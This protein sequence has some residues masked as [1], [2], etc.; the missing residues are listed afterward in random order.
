MQISTSVGE[1]FSALAKV[2]RT[3]K[4]A[5]LD[6]SN[7][8]FRSKYASL[9]SVLAAAR[10]ACASEGISIIQLAGTNEG[11]A[12]VTTVLGHSS[13]EWISSCLE[14]PLD[15]PT[16]QGMGSALT[17]ARR[18]SLAAAVGIAAEEDDDGNE[19]ERFAP[20]RQPAPARPA[21]QA[22][23]PAPRQSIPAAHNPNSVF[24]FPAGKYKG[25]DIGSLSHS[26]LSS[27]YEFF[28]AKGD[29]KGWVAEALAI[30]DKMLHQI[31]DDINQ[32][33]GNPEEHYSNANLD[34]IPF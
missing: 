29:A 6:A 27:W 7:P 34:N 30:A 25:R 8:H 17:Y 9:T 26:E 23:A 19:A 11:R 21:Q 1:L 22:Q 16:A 5:H 2:Q 32:T 24:V 15:K 14:V 4:D 10:V 12:T 3:I 13:G 33:P 18:Y 31:R 28:A 20:Q